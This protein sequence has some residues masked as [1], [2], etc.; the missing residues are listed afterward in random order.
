M[1]AERK[2]ETPEEGEKKKKGKQE[3]IEAEPEGKK[4]AGKEAKVGLSHPRR[5]GYCGSLF[6]PF[7]LG[8]Y[9]FIQDMITPLPVLLNARSTYEHCM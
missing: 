5:E 4:D 8:R 7:D 2:T 1:L 6:D 3:T 9:V